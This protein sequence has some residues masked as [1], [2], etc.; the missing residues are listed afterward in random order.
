M[1]RM[2]ARRYRHPISIAV[3]VFGVFALIG[4]MSNNGYAGFGKE[5]GS[6]PL[7]GSERRLASAVIANMDGQASNVG[8]P[9]L[10]DE[11]TPTGRV[12]GT[13][14]A[15]NQTLDSLYSNEPGQK[16]VINIDDGA[17]SFLVNQANLFVQ[18]DLKASNTFFKVR[19]KEGD[20]FRV[21]YDKSVTVPKGAILHLLGQFKDSLGSV[22][23]KGQVLTAQGG[24]KSP[25]W[26]DAVPAGVIQFYA[27]LGVPDGWLECDG[28]EVSEE[29][30]PDLFAALGT[31]WGPGSS[32]DTFNLPDLRGRVPVGAGDG[33][34]E[35][36]TFT[37][38]RLGATGGEEKHTL[39][40]AELPANDYLDGGGII[41]DQIRHDA[42]ANRT[43]YGDTGTSTTAT[44]GGGGGH[45]V[46]QP[47]AVVRCIIKT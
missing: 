29:A 24:A 47:F 4:S 3:F 27:G 36:D 39:T 14:D 10:S 33:D 43:Y 35:N 46:M 8:S 17:L 44:T 31:A 34:G 22:G 37:E 18:V 38:R 42:D 11:A 41:T 5:S 21:G 28:R 26:E 40:N 2:F 23:S 1:K 6:D 16:R 13:A 12:A 9:V 30:Y 45:N 15:A 32:G 25:Q 20:L 19:D 7:S